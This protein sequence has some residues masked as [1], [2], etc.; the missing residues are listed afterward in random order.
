MR[1]P[2]AP[3]REPALR[4]APEAD[5]PAPGEGFAA[6]WSRRKHTART[7]PEPQSPPPA[8][9]EPDTAPSPDIDAEPPGDTEMPPLESLTQDS[10]VSPFFS[11]RVTEELR[12]LAL[13]RL[14]RTPKFNLRDGLDDYDGDYRSFEPL[15]DVITADM[16]HQLERQA[17]LAK[18]LLESDSPTALPEDTPPALASTDDPAPARAASAG[19]DRDEEAELQSVAGAAS[20]HDQEVSS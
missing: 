11:P 7:S 13:R 9:Q 15:G 20:D 8:A 1:R 12:K 16:R 3:D 18:A 17:E 14:F 6:R 10:D 4:V 19:E 5:V 2:K